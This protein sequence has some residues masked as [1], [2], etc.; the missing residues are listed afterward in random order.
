MSNA[1]VIEQNP[2]LSPILMYV[3]YTNDKTKK[4]PSLLLKIQW[5][6]SYIYTKCLPT[7]RQRDKG[8]IE[9]DSRVGVSLVAS[10]TP[11]HSLCKVLWHRELCT[12]QLFTM[13][14]I[15]RNN[16]FI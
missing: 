12:N 16:I 13:Y 7:V 3:G 14:I 10:Y 11:R 1:G 4:G 8:T 6:Q 2:I 15:T 9:E 5:I